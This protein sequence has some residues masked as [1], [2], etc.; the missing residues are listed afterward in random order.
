MLITQN[1]VEAAAKIATEAADVAKAFDAGVT[2]AREAYLAKRDST[3][4]WR[5]YT[6]AMDQLAA[7]NARATAAKELHKAVAHAHHLEL[8]WHRLQS[9]PLV[10]QAVTTGNWPQPGEPILRGSVQ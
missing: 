10:L 1:T 2:E 3:A 9:M 5:A 6:H 8:A 7:A 4:T